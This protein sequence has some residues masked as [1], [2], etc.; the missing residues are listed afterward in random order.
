MVSPSSRARDSIRA[1]ERWHFSVRLR[2]PHGS[3]N[4][5]GFDY[6]SWLLQ[7]A[8]GATGYVRPGG[9]ARLDDL[10]NLPAS[11]LTAL[12]I[13]AAAAVSPGASAA[14]AWRAVIRDAP[15]HRSPNAGWPEA[16]IAV[17]LNVALSGPRSYHGEMRDFPWVWPEGRRQIGPEEIDAACAALWRA[18]GAM[19]V[20]VGL[21][22]LS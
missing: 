20:L 21:I 15:R 5:H 22:A 16:A 9:T 18:W 3:A 8:I 12:L 19:V 4:P 10:V 13:V 11:R 6:E 1:G 2:R 7:R 17:V 14:N